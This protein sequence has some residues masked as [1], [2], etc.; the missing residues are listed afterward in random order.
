MNIHELTRLVLSLLCITYESSNRRIV[1]F[2]QCL[3]TLISLFYLIMYKVTFTKN[4]DVNDPED[5][6]CLLR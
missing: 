5:H 6:L 3:D 4:D 1:T 2:L